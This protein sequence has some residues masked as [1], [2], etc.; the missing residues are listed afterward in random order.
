[1][2]R[3]LHTWLS[4]RASRARIR[5]CVVPRLRGFDAM[6]VNVAPIAGRGEIRR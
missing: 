6:P 4:R 1:M 2:I 3:A 5:E